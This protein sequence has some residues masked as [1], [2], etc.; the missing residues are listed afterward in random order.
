MILKWITYKYYLKNALLSWIKFRDLKVANKFK[1]YIMVGF[2][3]Y[4]HLKV[5]S[6]VNTIA[7]V[8]EPLDKIS[9]LH[10]RRVPPIIHV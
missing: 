8:E 1:G 3:S 6:G 2:F 7:A 4:F 5:G 10:D 9:K